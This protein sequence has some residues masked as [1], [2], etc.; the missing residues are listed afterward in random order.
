MGEYKPKKSTLIGWGIG[1]FGFQMMI[2]VSVYYFA[3]FLTDYAQF[4]VALSGFI[5]TVVGIG[6]AITQP[7]SGVVVTQARPKWG[8]Y[9]SW[10]LIGPPLI[11]IFFIMGYTKIGSDITAAAII[12]VTYVA[13]RFSFNC[14]WAAHLALIPY[15]SPKP[16]DRSFLSAS[17]GVW[18]QLGAFLFSAISLSIMTALVG[19]FG[20]VTGVTITA[21]FFCLFM[22]VGYLL[23][24][25]ATKGVPEPSV[26]EV[27]EKDKLSFMDYIRSIIKNP[28][29]LVALVAYTCSTLGNFMFS[30]FIFYYWKYTTDK[31]LMYSVFMTV[32]NFVALGGAA[33]TAWVSGKLGTKNTTVIGFFGNALFCVL[34]YF[35]ASDVLLF[36]VLYMISRVFYTFT[37]GT[38]ALIFTHVGMY[39]QWKT[40]KDN[41]A[42]VTGLVGVPAKIGSFTK[43]ALLAAGL[44]AMGFVANEAATPQ[45]I[46]GI[47]K[48]VA[49]KPGLWYLAAGI[50]MLFY[51]LN[52]KVVAEMDEALSSEK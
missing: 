8:K 45:V 4:P 31:F 3:A 40:G 34:A 43:G 41:R 48:E 32:S 16:E 29:L 13:C 42:F 30:M 2:L 26:V 15:I 38:N 47:Y 6:D 52:N 20:N 49:L 14:V 19:K 23:S 18:Q 10:Y 17:R 5:L 37:N 50:A 7:F 33:L 27:K 36:S 35:F 22:I 21:A 24:F 28:P 9:R 1:D 46:A 44:T 11:A 39:A 25:V 12:I 51:G